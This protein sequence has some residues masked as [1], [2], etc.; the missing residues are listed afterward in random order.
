[1]PIKPSDKEEEYFIRIELEKRKKLE[2]EKQEKLFGAERSKL[3]ELHHM[4][5]P[6]CG[7]QLIEIDYKDVK[8]DQCSEC[9]GIWLD[10]NELEEI[11]K[12]EHSGFQKIFKIFSK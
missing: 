10:A 8:I 1:M 2:A 6:K 3:K 5:C 4:R 7:M 11:I 12:L 9:N